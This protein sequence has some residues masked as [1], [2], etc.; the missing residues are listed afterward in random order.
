MGKTGFEQRAATRMISP[1]SKDV[2]KEL[3]RRQQRDQRKAFS[4]LRDLRVLLLKPPA[5][6]STINSPTLNQLIR[7]IREI[8]GSIQ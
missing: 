1:K 4:P 5:R 7:V 8:R 6:P 2:K 3:N